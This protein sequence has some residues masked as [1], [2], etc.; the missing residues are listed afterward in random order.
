MYIICIY[1]RL[2]IDRGVTKQIQS[3]DIFRDLPADSVF[4]RGS[5]S[6]STALV[7]EQVSVLFSRDVFGQ[8]RQS[9]QN[10]SEGSSKSEV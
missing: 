7:N 1:I 9:I 10:L 5:I 6:I 4:F 8:R 2:V 3:G